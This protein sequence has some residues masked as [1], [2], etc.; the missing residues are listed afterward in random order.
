MKPK[1]WRVRRPAAAE[2]MWRKVGWYS[3]CQSSHPC[4]MAWIWVMMAMSVAVPM[5]VVAAVTTSPEVPAMVAMARCSLLAETI[6]R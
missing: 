5:A 4:P 3:P 2:A 1:D 6:L